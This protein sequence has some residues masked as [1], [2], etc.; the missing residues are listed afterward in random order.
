[1]RMHKESQQSSGHV[2]L[3]CSGLHLN[4]NNSADSGQGEL[5]S[6]SKDVKYGCAVTLKNDTLNNIIVEW[7]RS[8]LSL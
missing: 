7:P 2:L 4:K 3:K 6:L 1:M 5:A 8:K